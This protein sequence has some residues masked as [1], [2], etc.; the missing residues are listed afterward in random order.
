MLDGMTNSFT[1]LEVA[2]YWRLT[3]SQFWECSEEDRAYM[4]A[5]AEAKFEME[6]IDAEKAR[7]GK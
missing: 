4:T 1:D 2:H 3:P 7:N 5:F 6:A